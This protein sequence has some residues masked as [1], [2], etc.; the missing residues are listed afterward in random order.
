MIESAFRWKVLMATNRLD[1][2]DDALI[3][4]GTFAKTEFQASVSLLEFSARLTSY[5]VC[6]GRIDRKIEFPNPNEKARED[7]LKIHVREQFILLNDCL[8]RVHFSLGFYFMFRLNT[9]V[10]ENEFDEGD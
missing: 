6:E 9:T 2:L 7:I 1:I 4:P 8:H 5:P 3:R 10:K